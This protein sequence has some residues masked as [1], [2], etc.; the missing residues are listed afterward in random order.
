MNGMASRNSTR[1][2]RAGG[3]THSTPASSGRSA[4]GSS[5]PH[6]LCLGIHPWL[7][8]MAI[9][10][11][12]DQRCRRLQAQRAP[13]NE[14]IAK[15]SLERNREDA[16]SV[17]VCAR[18]GQR[19]SRTI[20]RPAMAPA[21]RAREAIPISTPTVGFG[22]VRWIRSRRQLRMGRD[23][24]RPGHPFDHDAGVRPRRP[25]EQGRNDRQSPIMSAPCRATPRGG[26]RISTRGKQLF[27]DNCAPAM[28]KTARAISSSERRT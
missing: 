4:I 10:L 6:G 25:P 16:G 12:R 19:P 24:R 9:A 26:R 7:L 5:I 8:W 21:P 11:G 22:A 28:A 15:A 17:V 2:C 27:A 3:S 13:M 23:G 1:R 20:A 14:K 18:G